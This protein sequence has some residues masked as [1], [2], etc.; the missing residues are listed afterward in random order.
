MYAT[1]PTKHVSWT[2]KSQ[3]SQPMSKG[4]SSVLHVHSQPEMVK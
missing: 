3:N 2:N 1:T 4:I